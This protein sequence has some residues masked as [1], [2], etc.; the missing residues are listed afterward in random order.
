MANS[1]LHKQSYGHPE[2]ELIGALEPDQIVLAA[3]QPLPRYVVSPGVNL[4]LWGL[5][6]FVLIITV[7]V[8]YTF[9]VSLP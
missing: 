7:L 5:R 6:I 9:V 2:D 8:V 4:A 3:S 1:D